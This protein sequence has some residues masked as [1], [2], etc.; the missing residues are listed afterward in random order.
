MGNLLRGYSKSQGGSTRKLCCDLGFEGWSSVCGM[1]CRCVYLIMCFNS[2]VCCYVITFPI[3]TEAGQGCGSAPYTTAEQPTQVAPNHATAFTVCQRLPH[4]RLLGNG[5][6]RDLKGN[7]KEKCQK[8]NLVCPK[9][10]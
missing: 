3:Q 8:K 5:T 10:H 4:H 9:S 1:M 2:L 6:I 7:Q